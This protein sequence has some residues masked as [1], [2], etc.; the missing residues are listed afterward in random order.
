M[1]DKNGIDENENGNKFDEIFNQSFP[2]S[3][4]L[5][6]LDIENPLIEKGINQSNYL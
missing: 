6:K 3:G 2:S 4:L 5:S 1:N